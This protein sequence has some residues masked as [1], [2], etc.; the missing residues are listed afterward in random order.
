MFRASGSGLKGLSVGFW[1]LRYLWPRSKSRSL[2]IYTFCSR[3]IPNRGFNFSIHLLV[4][5]CF[6]CTSPVAIDLFA[7]K[8]VRG[9]SVTRNSCNGTLHGEICWWVFGS[10]PRLRA[11]NQE[12][13]RM[14]CTTAGLQVG[15]SISFSRLAQQALGPG[16]DAILFTFWKA[17]HAMLQNLEI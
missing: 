16:G 6:G 11:R 2:D 17:C 13:A 3:S 5:F 15:S 1:M 4:F 12:S 9:F 8:L 10:T 7:A 14:L